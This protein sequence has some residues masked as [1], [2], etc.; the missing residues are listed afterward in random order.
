MRTKP[1]SSGKSPWRSRLFRWNPASNMNT[2]SLISGAVNV[3]KSTLLDIGKPNS[4]TILAGMGRSGTTWAGEILNYDNRYR[5]LF[6]PFFPAA[7]QEAEGF[8]Y[9][10]YLNPENG[11]TKLINQA[12]RILAGQL[13]NRRVDRHNTRLFYRERLVKEIRCNFMLGWLKRIFNPPI[14]LI[15]RHPLQIVSSWSKL[16]WEK[17]KFGSRNDFDIITSQQALLQDFPIVQEAMKKI[18]H[19]DFV[20]NIVFQWCLYN[21]IPAKQLKETEAHTIFYENLLLNPQ[22]EIRKLFYYL[23]RPCDMN[24]LNSKINNPSRTNFNQRDITSDRT[25]MLN[26][27]KSEF[28]TRQIKRAYYI[29]TLFGMSDLYDENGYPSSPSLF[30]NGN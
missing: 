22:T 21:F 19:T 10:Q 7:V 13:R 18:D 5:V 23:G 3:F 29:L 12:R 6:E 9:I 2:R 4:V 24:K 15:V 27:W 14:I 26:N 17:E 8:E 1:E 11:N 16:R 20:E 28:S 25:K 30:S